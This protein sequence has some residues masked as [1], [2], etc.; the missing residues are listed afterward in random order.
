[1]DP[2]HITVRESRDSAAN[3]E[4]T[5]VILALDGTGSMRETLP[6]LAKEGLGTTFE[7]IIE[8]KPVSD[9]HVLLSMFGDVDWDHNPLVVGQFESEVGP[10]TAYLEK[11][12]FQGGGGNDH[13]S[14]DLIWWFAG[15]KTSI[16][17]FEKRSKKGYLF[18]IGDEEFPDRMTVDQ[19]HRF[20]DADASVGGN[21]SAKESLAMAQ[22]MYHVFHIVVEE[23]DYAR[24]RLA[25]TMSSWQAHLGQFVIPLSDK[26]KL[27]EVII[28]T[29][30]VHSGSDKDKVAKSWDGTTNLV[31]SHAIKDLAVG[32]KSDGKVVR[33]S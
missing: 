12:V 1:M 23:G 5:A 13:E 19:I 2:V 10:L 11:L 26:T 22:R 16:D 3:T 17:C 9:P 8:R 6:Y 32:A 18:T 29:L 21:V 20:L 27:A 15:Q 7:G 30:Q 31:V 24:R 28:S 33:L 14:E 25:Q 4:S